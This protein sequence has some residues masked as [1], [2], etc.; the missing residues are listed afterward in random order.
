MQESTG[1]ESLKREKDSERDAAGVDSEA[2]SKETLSDI[3]ETEKDPVSESSTPDPGPSPDGAL[4]EN[5][6]IK[7]A[8]PM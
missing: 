2:T 7:D 1:R 8:G 6:E 4:D 3:E 5:D